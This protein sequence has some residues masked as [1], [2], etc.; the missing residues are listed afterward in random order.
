MPSE[1][2]FVDQWTWCVQDRLR[3]FLGWDPLMDRD[4]APALDF[5]IDTDFD[6][7]AGLELLEVR[8]R[9]EMPAGWRLQF[10]YGKRLYLPRVEERLNPIDTNQFRADA[11]ES[12]ETRRRFY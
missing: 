3:F 6:R 12:F 11:L 1:R 2:V 9:A 4:Y 10:V 5:G 7:A 8:T